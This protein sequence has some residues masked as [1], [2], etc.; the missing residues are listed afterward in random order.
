MFK[1]IYL[2]RRLLKIILQ[3]ITY[4]MSW[5]DFYP[6]KLILTGTILEYFDLDFEYFSINSFPA[7]PFDV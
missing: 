6:L 3:K 7:V 1:M 4:I 5:P 2:Y